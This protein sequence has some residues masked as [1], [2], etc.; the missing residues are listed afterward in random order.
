MHYKKILLELEKLEKD[1]K[2]LLKDFKNNNIINSKPN[3]YLKQDKKSFKLLWIR[4]ISFFEKLKKLMR[5]SKYRKWI[6]L[7]DYN[8]L[9]LL[10]YMSIMYFNILVDLLTV[11]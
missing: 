5:A 10:R 3:Y 8:K 11:F 1:Y 7:F 4:Y 9:V 6:I 2:L